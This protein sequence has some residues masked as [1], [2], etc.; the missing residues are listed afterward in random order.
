MICKKNLREK[1]INCFRDYSFLLYEAKYK[2]KN[3]EGPK[4]LTPKQVLQRLPM[5]LAQLKVGNTSE[6]VFSLYQ[7]KEITK[8]L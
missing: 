1:I 8:K 5:A 7:S 6:N 2:A 4:I 3:G